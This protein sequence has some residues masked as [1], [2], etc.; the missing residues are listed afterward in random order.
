[1]NTIQKINQVEKWYKLGRIKKL[2][3][4]SF[5]VPPEA[6]I[7]GITPRLVAIVLKGKHD[8]VGK[9]SW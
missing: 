1:M 6:F 4:N 7:M 2:S 3:R 9:D 8:A 5:S